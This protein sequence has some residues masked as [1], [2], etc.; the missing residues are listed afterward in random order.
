MSTT[1]TDRKPD[2]TEW[3]CV[4]L[5][6][7]LGEVG[8]AV[9]DLLA[10][11]RARG[12][13]DETALDEIAL[14]ASEALTNAIRHGGGGMKD[15]AARLAWSLRG[16]E[17]EIEVSEPGE[18]TPAPGWDALPD[19]PLSEGG[20]GGFLLSRLMDAVE[21]RNDGGRHA[22]RLRRRLG[23]PG[24]GEGRRLAEAETALAQMTEEVGNAYET[25]ATLFSLAEGLAV[26]PDLRALAATGLARLGPVIAADAAWVRLAAEDGTLELLAADGAAHGPARLAPEAAAV[27]AAVA[28]AGLERTLADRALLPPGDPL[29]GSAGGAFVCPFSFEGRLRG[30]LTVTRDASAGGFFS[31]GQIAL[32][33]TL[34][35]FLGIACANDELRRQRRERLRSQRELEIASQIQRGLLPSVIAPH[36]A[37][38]VAGVCAQ[39]AEMGGD[40]FDVLDPSDGTRLVV[41]ADVM[42]KGVPA[43]LVAATLRTALRVLAGDGSGPGEL[44]TKVNRQLYPDLGRLGIFV[45]AQVLRLDA[46]GR[47]A[48][49]ASAGH[50]PILALG[51][52]GE[53]GW[54]DAVGGLPI[55]VAPAEVYQEGRAEAA[56]GSRLWLMTDGATEQED[57]SGVELGGE[58]FA[59][60]AVGARDPE[61]LRAALQSRAAGRPPRDDCTLVCVTPAGGEISP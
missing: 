14:A 24:G 29:L 55:G 38:T 12:A 39:A 61:A 17:L 57:T 51:A 50:C 22:L 49:Y 15:F 2:R 32:A 13:G 58:G 30:V 35:D 8:P 45:T 27:E 9:D 36:P 53:A 20:R 6:L 28:R 25:I 52:G 46:S 41:V 18:Y 21:H 23:E 11:L 10:W 7:D 1:P 5:G 33:R 60:L 44:L 16:G 48:S 34:A 54:W 56:P 19:D 47:G 59:R 4:H 40:F 37:W 26:T 43:A 31:A 3:A 42:G